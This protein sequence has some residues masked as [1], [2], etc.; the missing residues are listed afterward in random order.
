MYDDLNGDTQMLL[1]DDINFGTEGVGN[2]QRSWRRQRRRRPYR[3][4]AAVV[5]GSARAGVI[6]IGYI[7]WRRGSATIARVY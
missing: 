5:T 7:Y 3:E 6:L 2:R 1:P 4:T